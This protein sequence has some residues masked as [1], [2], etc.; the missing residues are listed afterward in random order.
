MK[1]FLAFVVAMVC[2]VSAQAAESKGE[3]W[4]IVPNNQVCMVTNVY[5]ER[6]QIP[7]ETSGKTYYGCC[8]NCKKTLAE[9]PTSRTAVDPVTKKPV[10]KAGAV[11]AANDDG[12]VL[13]FE[14]KKSFESY[15]KASKKK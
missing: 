6:K 15:A 13:Y 14:N 7:V 1:V 8:E 11:I 9:D 3:A 2:G 10:D 5:F 4:R 12:E